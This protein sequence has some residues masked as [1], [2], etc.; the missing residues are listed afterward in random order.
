[1]NWLLLSAFCLLGG[2]TRDTDAHKFYV[3][4]SVIEFNPRSNSY[5]VTCKIFTD[6][7]ELALET[8]SGRKVSLS[9]AQEKYVSEKLI[10]D[11][12]SPRFKVLFDDKPV[13]MSFVG[14]E[15]EVDLTYVYYEVSGNADFNVLTVENSLLFELYP[16]QKNIVDVRKSGWVK[17]VI[18]TKDHLRES[19][20]R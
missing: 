17:T 7:L 1:M 18:L 19:I 9:N 10:A 16:E 13:I 20:F 15:S 2:F 4:N 11:Y 8:S 12:V 3:S 5:E 6:D 14:F